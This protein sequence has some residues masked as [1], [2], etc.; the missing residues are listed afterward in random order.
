MLGPT[1]KRWL[2][3]ALLYSP[4]KFKLVMNQVPILQF[5]ALPYDRWEGY[6]AERAEILEFIRDHRIEGVVFLTADLHANIIAP[7]PLDPLEDPA[8]IAHE[9][10]VGPIAALPL[11]REL[12][13]SDPRGAGLLATVL[14]GLGAECRHFNAFTYGLVE[15]DAAGSLRVS[16][17]DQTGRVIT[18]EGTPPV[19]CAKTLAP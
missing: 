15:V 1:Q 8:P 7:V 17:R 6:A 14:D 4:A 10:V 18:G 12:N 11:E 2:K 13:R 5:Y 9:F 19:E 3:N 16:I